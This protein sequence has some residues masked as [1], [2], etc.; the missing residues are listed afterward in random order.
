[1]T[2]DNG[3]RMAAWTMAIA[4]AQ[5]NDVLAHAGTN[6]AFP[7]IT[8]AQYVYATRDDTMIKTVTAFIENPSG[9]RNKYEYDPCTETFRMH[10]VLYC[11]M[12]YPTD[13]GFI[14]DTLAGDG[15]P[16]D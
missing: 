11:S 16:L 15:D 7:V 6:A 12:H 13:Y 8:S 4:V 10:R 3:T 14:P 9:S 5:F 1:M 2:F